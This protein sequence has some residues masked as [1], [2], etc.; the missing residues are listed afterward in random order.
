VFMGPIVDLRIKTPD[1][2]IPLLHIEFEVMTI[3]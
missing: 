3:E 1:A 2:I